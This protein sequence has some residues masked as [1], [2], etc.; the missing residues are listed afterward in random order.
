MTWDVTVE[1]LPRP[2]AVFRTA[3]PSPSGPLLA[4][5]GVLRDAASGRPAII[6]TRLP[7]DAAGRLRRACIAYLGRGR[8]VRRTGGG[9]LSVTAA[10]GFQSALEMM[11]RYGCRPC[12]GY[13]HPAHATLA[14]SADLLAELCAA[15]DPAQA[16]ADSALVHGAV[17]PEWLVGGWWTSGV[18]NDTAPLPY[19]RDANNLEPAWS[20]M[21]ILRRGTTGGHLH[22]PEYDATLECRDRD[23]IWFPGWDLVHGVTPISRSKGG[24]RH[25]LVF[26]AV[27][28]MRNCVDPE[29]ELAR[30]RERRTA[31]EDDWRARQT[32]AGLLAEAPDEPEILVARD[33]FQFLVRP[34]SS[35]PKAVK[36]V[37]DRRSYFKHGIEI[38]PGET[39]VDLG[40]NIGTFSVM[41]AAAGASVVAYEPDPDSAALAVAN[42]AL[43]GVTVDVVQ[44]AVA[45]AAGT[46]TLHVNGARKNYWR[47]SLVK[48]WR[49]GSKITV[50]VLDYR[51]AIPPGANVKMD[52][53]GSEFALLEAMDFDS[54]GDLVFEWSFDI[55]RSIPR[56]RAV[57]ERLRASY[58]TVSYAKFDETLAEWPGSWFPPCR[59]VYCTRGLPGAH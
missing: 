28:R 21:V 56:F 36:E 48:A 12:A 2:E 7:E 58:P 20:A 44:A 15:A 49:G 9:F 23:V 14:D 53:E 26:Y 10:V 47:N 41:A 17:R 55:D 54:L 46:A 42:A 31:A 57:I 19:H 50:P 22:V 13:D 4:G 40:A 5:P 38:R 34:G 25:S 18:L 33:G 35:D 32:A 27:E 1:R 8:T 29:G 43:N 11:R 24:Y 45:T 6:V 37:V 16:A 30:G 59:T 52:V 39:W 3:A 51:E